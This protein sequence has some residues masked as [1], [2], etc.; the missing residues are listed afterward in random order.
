MQPSPGKQSG[1][2][3]HIGQSALRVG[4]ASCGAVEKKYPAAAANVTFKANPVANSD[5]LIIMV[6]EFNSFRSVPWSYN[7]V[8]GQVTYDP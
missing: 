3:M 6:L 8:I 2:G 4:S 5:F 7:L 1:M